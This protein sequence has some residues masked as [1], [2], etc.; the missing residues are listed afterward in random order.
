MVIKSIRVQNFK[1]IADSTTIPITKLFGLIGK[2]NSGKSA[3]IDAIRVF[4]GMRAITADDFHKNNKGDICIELCF[5]KDYYADSSEDK[6]YVATVAFDQGPKHALEIKD[7]AD[8]AVKPAAIKN[9]F[10]RLLV[11]PAIRNP[12]NE[13]TAGTKSYLKDLIAEILATAEAK[14]DGKGDPGKI[15]GKD[16]NRSQLLRLLQAGTKTQLKALSKKLSDNF[17]EAI[18]DQDIKLEIDPE[19]DLSKAL[20]YTT[21]IVD[22]HLGKGLPAVDILACGTGLQSMAILTL[23]QTYAQGETDRN[24]ILLVEEPEVYLHPDLQRKMFAALRG[25]A[26]RNQVI[27]TTHSPIMISE[28]W[29][30]HSIR[31]VKRKEGVTTFEIISVP[32]VVGELGIRYEDILNP[33][34]VVFVEG[35]ADE[36]FYRGLAGK[37]ASAGQVEAKIKFISTDGFKNIHAFALMNILL[38]HKV[39]SK[40]K[41][42]VDGDA[43]PEAGRKKELLEGIGKHLRHGADIDK[44]EDLEMHIISEHELE[45]FLLDATIL[46]KIMTGLSEKQIQ[47][48]LNFYRQTYNGAIKAAGKTAAAIQLATR[49]CKPSLLFED[50]NANP[51]H[52][53]AYEAAFKNNADFLTFRKALLV[54]WAAWKKSHKT[55]FD[56]LFGDIDIRKIPILKEPISMIETLLK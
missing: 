21:T 12:E 42:F 34:T 38:S 54:A 4:F 41:L 23:L 3:L 48:S 43:M 46:R 37:L 18:N 6:R 50:P 13:T 27:F 55:P 47:D 15:A 17:Q 8:K 26:R 14:E 53:K 44:L 35:S 9:E 1:S 22:P 2:N 31:L 10:P 49:Y 24:V 45:G 56:E 19:G 39:R 30:D 52:I 32:E 20:N 28:L 5:A 40:A 51:N 7:E 36:E 33:A 29:V 16:L 11:I 25:I